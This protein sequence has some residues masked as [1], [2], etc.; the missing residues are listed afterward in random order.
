MLSNVLPSLVLNGLNNG[1]G[2][3]LDIF[4]DYLCGTEAQIMKF[5]TV[6][7][8]LKKYLDKE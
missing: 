2:K 7:N 3:F 8:T 6:V 4:L 5:Q 1:Y